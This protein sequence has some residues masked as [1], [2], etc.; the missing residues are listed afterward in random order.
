LMGNKSVRST[1]KRLLGLT[2]WIC[3]HGDLKSLNAI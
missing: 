2:K 1:C 3:K